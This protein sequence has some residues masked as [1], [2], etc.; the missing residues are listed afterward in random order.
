MRTKSPK[1]VKPLTTRR[2]LRRMVGCDWSHLPRA[3]A[4]LDARISELR[5]RAGIFRG[6]EQR[7]DISAEI[8]ACINEMVE[9]K[10]DFLPQTS[11]AMKR[12]TANTRIT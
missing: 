11:D 9:A 2:S 12:Y 7:P 3:F 6:M 5:T 1:A 10:H 4:K 8:E